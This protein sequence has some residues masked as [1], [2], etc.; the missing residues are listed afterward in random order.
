ML[1]LTFNGTSDDI[2]FHTLSSFNFNLGK[3][4]LNPMSLTITLMLS[5]A[6]RCQLGQQQNYNT[7]SVK[8]QFFSQFVAVGILG[9][10]YI[11]CDVSC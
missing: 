10:F 5:K 1:Q 3:I 2:I 6:S 11:L 9:T 7:L 4:D 8:K